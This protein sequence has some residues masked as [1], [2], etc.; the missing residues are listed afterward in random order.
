MGKSPPDSWAKAVRDLP[1]AHQRLRNVRIEN[2][3]FRVIL[4]R[5]DSP[6][7]LFYLDPPYLGVQNSYRCAMSE[8]D[9]ES[10]L[11]HLLNLEGMAILSGVPSPLY[12]SLESIGWQRLD[13]IVRNESWHRRKQSGQ[14]QYRYESLWLCPKTQRYGRFVNSGDVE[15]V[16]LPSQLDRR[17][18]S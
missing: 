12:T 5:Y 11:T 13:W 10:L 6:T 15:T 1:R 4:G 7:T 2:E 17:E 14:A 3:D 8:S 18:V 16:R 9:H